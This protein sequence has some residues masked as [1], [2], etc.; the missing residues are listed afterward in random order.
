MTMT[1]GCTDSE[2]A[3]K[4]IRTASI[5]VGKKNLLIF[6]T[7]KDTDLRLTNTGSKEFKPGSQPPETVNSI[8]VNPDKQF[9]KILG[10]GG[11][12][13]DASAEVFAK[14][15]ENKQ[16]EFLEA[17]FDK[18]NGIG[19]TLARITI[20]SA[21]FSSESFTY[22]EDGDK[23][24]TS[25]SIDRD[26]NFRIPLIKRATDAAGGELLLYASPWSAPAFMKTNKSMLFGGKLLPEYYDSWARYYVKFIES[27]EKEGMPM[28]GI[29]IQNEPMAVQ[30]WESMIYTAE[31]E[32][33]FLKN[34]LGPIM[35]QSG[36]GDKN[37]VVWDHNRDLMA[38]RA[39]VIF[40]DPEASKYAW[41]IGYHWYE[42]WY[43]DC[44]PHCDGFENM[45]ENLALVNQ[46][47]PDKPILFTEGTV[48]AFSTDKYQYWP[49]AERYGFSMIRDFNRGTVGWTDWNLL[50]DQTGG[51]NHVSNFCFAPIH[52]DTST[53]ELI[54]T[55]TYF[56]IGHCF[57]QAMESTKIDD[58]GHNLHD[59]VCLMISI[60]FWLF[61]FFTIALTSYLNRN[62]L[63]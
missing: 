14:L 21:D 3:S 33:D 52:G 30:R 62:S 47:F 43:T 57:L 27:Y 9:Q 12:I 10:F 25:F 1:L 17:Y 55:P 39:N 29:S 7:A 38:H 44:Y 54:Y 45:H 20:H 35:E 40:G 61:G 28:W 56:Y 18:E 5:D 50:L 32:R 58:L 26:K 8:F 11:S 42:T 19:Y 60:V 2:S 37:I 23:E 24:L 31:E 34:H 16:Q 51:P 46:S 49:N 63:L 53:G 22:V 6:T 4:L 15:P 13:T 59:V 36:Y 48:E 41:G